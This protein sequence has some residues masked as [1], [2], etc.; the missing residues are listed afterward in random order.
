MNRIAILV[1]IAVLLLAVQPLWAGQTVSQSF[2]IG[3]YIPPHV[4]VGYADAN[5]ISNN[6][7]ALS[8]PEVNTT[9]EIVWQDQQ[10]IVLQTTVVR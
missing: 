4:M 3:V 5:A 9:V 2:T 1:F 10:Q 8:N 7:P 6:Q